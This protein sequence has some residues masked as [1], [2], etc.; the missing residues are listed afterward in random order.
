MLGVFIVEAG[1]WYVRLCFAAAML[2]LEWV[3]SKT[4]TASKY[5]GWYRLGVA[6]LAIFL[7]MGD[8]KGG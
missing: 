5:Y 8:S 7:E 4:Y 6:V 1:E 3:L 2:L